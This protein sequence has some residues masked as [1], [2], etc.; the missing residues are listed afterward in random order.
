VAR[1]VGPISGSAVAANTWYPAGSGGR[2]ETFRGA[3]LTY[4]L[5]FV[6]NF[7]RELLAH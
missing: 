4:G 1:I 5:V 2:S 7:A 6:R 3:G